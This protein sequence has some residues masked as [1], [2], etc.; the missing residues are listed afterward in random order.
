MLTAEQRQFLINYLERGIKRWLH[1]AQENSVFPDPVTYSM[2]ISIV[3]VL[4][5]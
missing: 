1:E 3:E 4:K 5:K 2:M